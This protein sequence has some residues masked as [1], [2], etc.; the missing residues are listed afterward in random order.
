MRIPWARSAR[1]LG[2]AVVT[3]LAL[4]ATVPGTAAAAPA[5]RLP[6]SYV[7]MSGHDAPGP[8]THDRIHVLK[9]GSARARQVLVL[10]PGQFG[11]AGSFGPLARELA[12]RLPGTQVWAV[13]RREQNLSDL[14]GFRRSPDRAADHYLGGHYRAQT[15][16]T[17]PY[18]GDWGLGVQLA[19]LRRVVLAARDGGRRQVVL[20]GHSWGATTALAYAG[21]DFAGQPGYRDLSGLVLIDGG[22]H[23]AFAGEGYVYRLTTDQADDRLGK[24]AAG[25]IFDES[26]TMGRTETFAILQQLA[27][28]YAQAAPDQPS[29]LAA[30][31]P[32]RLRPPAQVT[33][34][35]LVKWLYVTHPLVPDMSLNPDY[36]S[37]ATFAGALSGPVPSM[38]EWYWPS[39]LSLDL[40]A[41]DPFDDTPVARRLGLRLW[42]TRG[43]DVPLYSFQSGLTHGTANTAARWVAAHSRIT[44]A[45]YAGNDAM[46]HLDPL[47]ASP[48]KNTFL[49]TVTPF[50]SRL[51]ER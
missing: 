38:L 43:M 49:T 40:E 15:P 36:T 20:G 27:G 28:R 33:N 39:R 30:H 3:G 22:V 10:L 12:A 2:C 50:L 14:R 44:E 51:S 7:S 48:E 46:T 9:V 35:G 21:W 32:D 42:H 19:D 13:D 11:A 31:L 47:F 5:G 23:D 16:R 17:V 29:T 18:V 45:T 4:A 25:E 6:E 1:R 8:A 41:A 34:E 37:T 24:I 26:L